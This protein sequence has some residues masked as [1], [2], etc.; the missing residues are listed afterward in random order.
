[1]NSK[2]NIFNR[3]ISVLL[4]T[5]I[6][7]TLVSCNKT[8]S[9]D[10]KDAETVMTIGEYKVRR[11]LYGYFYESFIEQY[12]MS[13]DSFDSLTD[14]QKEAAEK[15]VKES[16]V[17]SLKKLYSIYLLAAENGIKE[18]DSELSSRVDDY[19]SSVIN[20]EYGG[21]EESMR[22]DIEKMHMTYEAFLKAAEAT[23]LQE[24]LYIKLISDG[25]ISQDAN[26]LKTAFLSTEMVRTKHI[27]IGYNGTLTAND[28]LNDYSDAKETVHSKAE[29]VKTKIENGE[30]FDL[31]IDEYNND[32]LM[33]KN[34]DGSYFTKGNKDLLY[35]E[36]AFALEIGE[37]SDV[38]YT[39]EGACIIKRLELSEDYIKRN[40]YTLI[41][42]YSEG[43]FNIMLEDA[44]SR[45]EVSEITD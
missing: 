32:P 27:L 30:D 42:S 1:M 10:K 5:V 24:M 3:A 37:T 4:C 28:I 13:G 12:G 20:S 43:I 31:L 33:M 23:Q 14:S 38:I 15:K 6:S 25:K 44:A 40:L 36:T 39:S 34:P 7:A 29:E 11:D 22:K 26:E 19:V 41:D 45:L 16:T 8:A 35:E 2:M 17:N 21:S 9:A 18:S